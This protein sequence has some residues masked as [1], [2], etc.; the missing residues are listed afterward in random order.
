MAPVFLRDSK[1]P[2]KPANPA[3]PDSR[4]VWVDW[5]KDA[6]PFGRAATTILA[7]S[8]GLRGA[9]FSAR[10]VRAEVMR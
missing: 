4:A 7:D 8:L 3:A 2:I 9:R 5:P 10:W 6:R 1:M